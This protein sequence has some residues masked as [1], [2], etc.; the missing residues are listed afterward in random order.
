MKSGADF[1]PRPWHP[2]AEYY[3]AEGHDIRDVIE[4][5]ELNY[6]RGAVVKYMARAGRKPGNDPLL[7]LLKAREHINREI[8]RLGGEAAATAE[9]ARRLAGDRAGAGCGE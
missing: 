7:D 3:I 8:A 6:N 4:A 5:F 2:T 9:P 1:A